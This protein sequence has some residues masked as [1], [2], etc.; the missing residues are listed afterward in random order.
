M[1]VC[2][3]TYQKMENHEWMYKRRPSQWDSTDE[4]KEKTGEFVDRAF[5]IDPRP[6]GT[7]CPCSKYQNIRRHSNEV[8]TKHLITHGFTTFYHVW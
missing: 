4:W 6:N 2:F 8:V 3:G 5:R 1:H 7:W